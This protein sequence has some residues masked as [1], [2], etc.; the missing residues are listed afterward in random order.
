MCN[1]RSCASP[2]LQKFCQW[3][4]DEGMVK[5]HIQT[6]ELMDPG[7][8]IRKGED[9]NHPLELELFESLVAN[10]SGN[11]ASRERIQEVLSNRYHKFDLEMF[12][13]CIEEVFRIE[14][15]MKDGS[16]SFVESNCDAAPD[17]NRI[18]YSTWITFKNWPN[19]Q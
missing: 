9:E 11:F 7:Y 17:V 13:K 5:M 4:R 3:F 2:I 16:I 15:G 19:G 14:Q 18:P 12:E 8:L 10:S 1:E 6:K